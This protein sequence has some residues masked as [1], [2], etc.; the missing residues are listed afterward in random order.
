MSRRANKHL[1]LG[2]QFEE[3][4]P[5]SGGHAHAE[6]KAGTRY[7][8][9][10]VPGARATKAYVCPSCQRAVG[11]GVAHIVAWP[12]TPSWGQE[13]AVDGRRHWHTGCWNRM[14]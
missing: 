11:V 6:T 13:R 2:R 12:D 14:R 3:V 4:R 8:V 7:I 1:R 5:L 9:R 10:S